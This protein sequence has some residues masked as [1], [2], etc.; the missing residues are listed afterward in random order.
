MKTFAFVGVIVLTQSIGTNILYRIN[1]QLYFRLSVMIF[2]LARS[3]GSCA[4]NAGELFH[5]L[6]TWEIIQIFSPLL[7]CLSAILI[8]CLRGIIGALFA[9]CL[10]E[11]TA[12]PLVGN[13]TVRV[14]F[15]KS[16]FN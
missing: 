6:Y 14:M 15:R 5:I 8:Y 16:M 12:V 9:A 13:R 4:K 11:H 1:T 10:P 7:F 3:G 2:L